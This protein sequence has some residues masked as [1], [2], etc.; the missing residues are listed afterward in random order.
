MFG[1]ARVLR[2]FCERVLVESVWD[3]PL[4]FLFCDLVLHDDVFLGL[5]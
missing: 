5:I 3:V 4:I 1:V 2:V